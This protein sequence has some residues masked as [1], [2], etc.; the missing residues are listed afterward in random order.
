VLRYR[1]ELVARA[2]EELS[3]LIEPIEVRR[4]RRD[5]RLRALLGLAVE[6]SAWHRER[7]GRVNLTAVAGDDL[8]DLPV[9]TK[10]DVMANW[11]TIVCDP[12]L[13]L[14]RVSAHLDRIVT[15]GPELLD[16]T[17]L[18]LATGGSTGTRGVFVWDIADFTEHM[19]A[20]GRAAAWNARHR[21][22]AADQLRRAAVFG[23]NPV[24]LSS[25]LA[26]LRGT[27]IRSA[28]TPIAEL[29]EW[30]NELQPDALGAYASVLGRLAEET[31][32]GRL[33]ISPISVDSLAEPADE[34]LRDRIER[35]W[36][37]PLANVYGLTEAPAIA[38]SYEH[39][40]TLTLQDDIA[41]IEV[42]NA[43]G[44]PVSLGEPGEKILLTTLTNRTLPLVRYEVTDQLA[45]LDGPVDRAPNTRR[46]RP[47]DRRLRRTRHR[48]AARPPHLGPFRM[49]HGA[50][51]G[52]SHPR[53]QPSTTPPKQQT[54]TLRSTRQLST[55]STRHRSRSAPQPHRSADRR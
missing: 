50:A 24:H 3:R 14:D 25:T 34:Q 35:A 1:A 51:P 55:T 31:I 42:L 8:G 29:V 19:A 33:S 46:H 2:D 4:A 13:T 23:A 22:I 9:M 41:I 5:D 38:V 54:Q 26:W 10:A 39:S 48:V 11:D 45:L 18:V 30:L 32:S 15:S 27:E 52:R 49:R 36:G 53:G 47:D 17:Y 43:D 16:D 21:S 40:S 6:R 7:L 28:S 20:S 12:A 44:Q 37:C